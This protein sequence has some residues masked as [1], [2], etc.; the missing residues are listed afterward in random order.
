V[1]VLQEGVVLD[2]KVL[3]AWYERTW[4]EGVLL[5]ALGQ[6]ADQRFARVEDALAWFSEARARIPDFPP[7]R[8]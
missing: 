1:G 7:A 6:L 3:D 5:G 2:A 8:R 4:I